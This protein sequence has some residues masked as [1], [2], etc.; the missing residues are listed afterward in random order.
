MEIQKQKSKKK[1]LIPVI[2]IIGV[3]II[4]GGIFAYFQF[5]GKEV[6]TE[7]L[8]A[9]EV[10]KKIEDESNRNWCLARI[11]GDVSFCEGAS[12][13]KDDCVSA[14]IRDIAIQKKDSRGCG[15][16]SACYTGI[17]VTTQNLEICKNIKNEF[18]FHRCLIGVAVFGEN[19]NLCQNIEDDY[20][21]KECEIILRGDL[22]LCSELKLMDLDA[23]RCILTIAVLNNDS[24]VCASA[25]TTE[26]W[27]CYIDIAL[28]TKNESVCKNIN[29]SDPDYS[30]LLKN[31]CMAM[32]NKDVSFCESLDNKFY[33][34]DYCLNELALSLSG[35][36]IYTSLIYY[37]STLSE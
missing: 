11:N 25:K 27:L 26:E 19:I 32:V 13:V 15:D 33:Y 24:S 5:F 9:V 37:V 20:Y 7:E 30:K 18:L 31:N 16:D 22:S 36:R 34:K 29:E 14:V 28:R 12:G 10:C 4:G 23:E 3:L 2:I 21:K 17:A 35:L 8:S 1:F 6:K